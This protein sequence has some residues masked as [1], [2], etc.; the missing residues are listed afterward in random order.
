M[1]ES[2][3]GPGRQCAA[4]PSTTGGARRPHRGR[5]SSGP[6]GQRV[7]KERRSPG[8]ARTGGCNAC[9]DGTSTTVPRTTAG[10]L[11]GRSVTSW[12]PGGSSRDGRAGRASP[13]GGTGRRRHHDD[14]LVSRRGVGG[15]RRGRGRP[16]RESGPRS[17]LGARG[18]PARHGRR[19]GLGSPAPGD[20]SGQVLDGIGDRHRHRFRRLRRGHRLRRLQRA[21]G[22]R[23]PTGL[24]T[25]VRPGRRG[26]SS[27]TGVDAAWSAARSSA[28]GSSSARR[29]ASAT[30]PQ[31]RGRILTGLLR[32]GGARRRPDHPHRRG[33]AAGGHASGTRR[34]GTRGG[35]GATRSRQGRRSAGPPV[36][37]P[38]VPACRRPQRV[39]HG[40]RPAAASAA[41][42]VGSRKPGSPAS[43]S[44]SGSPSSTTP[45][46]EVDVRVPSGIGLADE[47]SD[48]GSAWPE[49]PVAIGPPLLAS[50]AARAD[51]RPRAGEGLVV[52]PWRERPLD[53]GLGRLP[54]LGQ[55]RSSSPRRPPRS[56]APARRP[57]RAVPAGLQL[58]DLLR[59]VGPPAGDVAQ[60]SRSRISRAS[61]TSSCP[62]PGPRR[63]SSW[64]SAVRAWS[65]MSSASGGRSPGPG[66]PRPP[67]GGVDPGPPPENS[68]S[69]SAPPGTPLAVDL[70][71]EPLG[72]GHQ[73]GR[74]VPALCQRSSPWR[75]ISARSSSVSAVRTSTSALPADTVLDRGQALL[76]PALG[77]DPHRLG[78]LLALTS[79]RWQS[80]S[81]RARVSVASARAES[82]SSSVSRAAI[83]VTS[84]SSWLVRMSARRPASASEPCR[85]G[86]SAVLEPAGV[87]PQ[88]VD[89][90]ASTAMRAATWSGS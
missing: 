25:V 36:R 23:P 71:L 6:A 19:F 87:G 20:S 78:P 55:R 66:R 10:T 89:R 65:R 68:H 14:R 42:P 47:S 32:V 29:A 5:P 49:G 37:G 28:A 12:S 88:P 16:G 18:R 58:L 39:R 80:L 63:A 56:G 46:I 35:T 82:S 51:R 26:G 31:R 22:R 70:L 85:A 17:T 4:P 59:S 76:A 1:V 90:S 86:T 21:R 84:A 3:P 50:L 60:S 79:R 15:R 81:A 72:L 43:G 54:R 73:P 45:S 53:G 34:A 11:T 74:L 44:A 52:V 2:D 24:S 77:L 62:R 8:R 38:A 75:S 69:R 33:P 57:S 9:P 41:G 7:V 64:A 40:A 67:G 13:R 30:G 27:G 83:S 48:L 61:S